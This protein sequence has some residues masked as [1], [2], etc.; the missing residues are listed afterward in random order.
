MTYD[1]AQAE[2]NELRGLAKNGRDLANYKERI[3]KLY[4]LVCRKTLRKCNCKNVLSDA[5][6]EIYAQLKHYTTHMEEF[7][8]QAR[9][10]NGVVLQWGGN[11]YTNNNLTDKVARDFLAKFPQR[12]NWFSTLPS[13]T[14]E[15]EV[16]AE[17]AET[18]EKRAE[19]APAEDKKTSQPNTA[20]KK[21]NEKKRR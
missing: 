14:S 20:K 16:V 19:I 2:F 18:P 15:K 7:K 4:Q 13:A 1:E 5:M 21:K 17:V 12:K 9:L 8:T 3:A 11:H 10:V 6:A